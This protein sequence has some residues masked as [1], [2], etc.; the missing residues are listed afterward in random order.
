MTII[1]GSKIL[2]TRSAY[3]AALAGSTF[4]SIGI[5]NIEKNE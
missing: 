2:T 5:Y 4:G 3:I 1:Q